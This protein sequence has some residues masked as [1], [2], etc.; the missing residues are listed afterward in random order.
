MG[1]A[2]TVATV[3]L[4]NLAISLAI[5]W[6]CIRILVTFCSSFLMV[7]ISVMFGSTDGSIKIPS[8]GVELARTSC[9]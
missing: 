1:S 3:F 7:Q 6:S 2:W 5:I 8:V 9:H 4:T